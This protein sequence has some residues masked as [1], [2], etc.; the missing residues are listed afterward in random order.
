VREGTPEDLRGAA[1]DPGKYGTL[2][3][4]GKEGTLRSRYVEQLEGT[5]EQLKALAQ[6][7]ANLKAEIERVQREIAS[8][9][10]PFKICYNATIEAKDTTPGHQL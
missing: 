4:T 1:P 3:Q 9:C 10:P 8:A 7:E 6:Q 2:A 5:E